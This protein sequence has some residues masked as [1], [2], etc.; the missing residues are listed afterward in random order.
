[1]HSKYVMDSI[2]IID[3]EPFQ[4]NEDL[5]YEEKPI[6]ILAREVKALHNKEIALSKYYGETITQKKSLGNEKMRQEKNTPSW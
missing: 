5:S 1:M 3:Y 4:I 2:H 6:K